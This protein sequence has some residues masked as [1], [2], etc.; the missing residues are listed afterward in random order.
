MEQPRTIFQ[1]PQKLEDKQ[2]IKEN[3]HPLHVWGVS[4]Q[5]SCMGVPP[6]VE[7]EKERTIVD[8]GHEI[9]LSDL[10]KRLHR[11]RVKDLENVRDMISKEIKRLEDLGVAND[12]SNSD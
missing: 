7:E 4:N 6:R 1:Q 11:Q 8:D 9:I 10:R 2:C 5:L 3:P 12:V